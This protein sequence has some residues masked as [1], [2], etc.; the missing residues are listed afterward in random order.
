MLMISGRDINNRQIG[1]Q[2]NFAIF[3]SEADKLI[4]HFTSAINYPGLTYVNAF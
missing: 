1:Q 2:L 3:M 4:S